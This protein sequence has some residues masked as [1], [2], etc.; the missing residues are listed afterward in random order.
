MVAANIDKI[1]QQ[2][3]PTV[4]LIVVSKNQPL[5]LV[6]EAYKSGHRAFGENKVQEL[7][8]KQQLLPADV[9]WHL[10]G[11]L[12]SN[13]VKYIAP[14]VQ[15]IHSV[16]SYKLLETINKEAQKNNRIINCLLQV[17]IASEETK[18][19]LNSAELI[20]VINLA[21]QNNLQHVRICGLMG[22]AS[23]TN[24]KQQ[25]EHEFNTLNTIF[26]QIKI[27]K[28]IDATT[29]TILSMGMS[30]DYEIAITCGSNMIRVGSLI[31][32]E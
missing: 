30:N 6:K 16:D 29:F 19:G 20:D 4:K 12:Q 7:V 18:F 21:Q 8:T 23:N 9:E 1:N 26:N 31:F 2:I 24:N 25:V 15:L 5:T 22:M 3:P 17:Y 10:I 11:H 28:N 27:D 14:F 32:A 13:K